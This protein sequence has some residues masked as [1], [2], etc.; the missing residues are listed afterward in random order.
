MVFDWDQN[1]NQRLIE[2]R[3]ISFE[4]IVVA[5]DSGKLVDILQHH[6]QKKYQDQ[7]LLIV[8]IDN[9]IWV[10]PTIEKKDSYFMKTAFPS[11]KFTDIYLPESRL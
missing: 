1:K 11:R 3:N 8:E 2:E 7:L 9:Y 5:I 4:R 6:N 10:V